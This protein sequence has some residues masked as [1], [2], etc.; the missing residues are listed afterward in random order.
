MEVL[1]AYLIAH[2]EVAVALTSVLGSFGVALSNAGG[3]K[4]AL[5]K[6]L[7]RLLVK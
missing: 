5:L 1:I 3:E 4:F 6:R 7:Y 2:P